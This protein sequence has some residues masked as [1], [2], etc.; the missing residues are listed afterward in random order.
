MLKKLI[1]PLSVLIIV[2]IIWFNQNLFKDHR[3][4]LPLPVRFVNLPE[5]RVITGIE[6]DELELIVE[7][8]GIDILRFGRTDYYLKIDV[9]LLRTG[10]NE[11]VLTEQDLIMEENSQKSIQIS[12]LNNV[13]SIEI[14]RTVIVNIPVQKRFMTIDDEFFFTRR[15]ASLHPETVEIVAPS[16]VIEK[17]TSVTTVPISVTDITDSQQ[18]QVELE[19]PDGILGIK[20]DIVTVVLESPSIINRTIPL[21]PI[22]YPSEKISLIIPQTVTV[23]VEGL[24]ERVQSLRPQMISAYVSVPDGFEY[25]FAPISFRLPEG[26]TLIDHTPQ[27]VQIIRED[28]SPEEEIDEQLQNPGN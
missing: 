25:D 2:L 18:L 10:I 9:S 13:I 27:R 6:P 14:D 22:Q 4:Q 1:L 17:L 24:A 15:N 16:S 11:L 8:K 23:K 5:E 3:T 19:I 28:D 12:F 21:I 20:P 7:G 26:V